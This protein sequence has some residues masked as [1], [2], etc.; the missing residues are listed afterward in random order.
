METG[1]PAQEGGREGRSAGVPCPEPGERRGGDLSERPRGGHKEARGPGPDGRVALTVDVSAE[2]A[3][4][5]SLEKALIV[6]GSRTPAS[7]MGNPVQSHVET[8]LVIQAVPADGAHLAVC[9]D[10]EL[11]VAHV[12]GEAHVLESE[13]VLH[14]PV[15][16]QEV[17]LRAAAAGQRR[18]L[19]H[20]REEE[21]QGRTQTRAG[22][23]P[24]AQSSPPRGSQESRDSAPWVRGEPGPP[25][26]HRAHL[27]PLPPTRPDAPA[28]L[29]A[30]KGSLTLG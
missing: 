18:L 14:Q 26:A 2:Q 8:V 24:A 6:G 5:Q 19:P 9:T 27:P 10:Q 12:L 15:L 16:L 23:L 17:A 20:G 30:P 7:L 11:D 25:Q 29:P 1:S 13:H 4:G 22:L 28:F 21:L 3:T